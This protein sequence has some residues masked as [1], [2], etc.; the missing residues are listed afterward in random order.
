MLLLAEACGVV[1]HDKSKQGRHIPPL[2][3][4]LIKFEIVCFCPSCELCPRSRF[5]FRRGGQE[6]IFPPFGCDSASDKKFL[7]IELNPNEKK[8]P[9]IQKFCF[10]FFVNNLFFL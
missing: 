10:V 4:P 1:G 5:F 6:N 2:N 8:N 7:K 3:M 9:D